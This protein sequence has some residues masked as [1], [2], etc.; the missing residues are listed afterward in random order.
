MQHQMLVQAQPLAL[1]PLKDMAQVDELDYTAD[2]D[3]LY[4]KTDDL[5]KFFK[6]GKLSYNM[7]KYIP[8][9]A[10]VGHRGQ[11]YLTETKRKYAM[12][13]TKT[14]KLQSLTSN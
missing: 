2:F 7:L 13:L 8:G 10:K 5:E 4:P 3:N 9:L 11:F 14:R 1:N 12:A 6:N